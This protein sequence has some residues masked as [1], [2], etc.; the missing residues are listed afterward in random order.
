MFGIFNILL[1]DNDN[2]SEQEENQN[3]DDM[4]T[5]IFGNPGEGANKDDDLASGDYKEHDWYD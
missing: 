1:G 2:C 4:F 5:S 3:E